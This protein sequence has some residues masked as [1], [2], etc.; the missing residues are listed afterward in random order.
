M[1]LNS[2]MPKK[3]EERRLF[4]IGNC[5]EVILKNINKIMYRKSLILNWI[6][7]IEEK[8]S[9]QIW[10]PSSSRKMFKKDRK[11]YGKKGYQRFQERRVW[12][13]PL[14][15]TEFT[16][17]LQFFSSINRVTLARS[18]M[19]SGSNFPPDMSLMYS[20]MAIDCPKLNKIHNTWAYIGIHPPKEKMHSVQDMSSSE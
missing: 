18:L 17:T 10:P 11:V 8:K 6:T 16:E 15:F 19:S 3:S 5:S 4:K 12:A 14:S 20:R 2:L 1:K 13:P 7:Q 9:L